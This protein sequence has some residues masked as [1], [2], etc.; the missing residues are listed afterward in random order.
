MLELYAQV[1]VPPKLVKLYMNVDYY[2]LN[3][4]RPPSRTEKKW[5]DYFTSI[6]NRFQSNKYIDGIECDLYIEI[7]GKKY[8]IEIDGPSHNYS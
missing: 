7:N 6:E 1:P 4:D 5:S 3:N 2:S 8:N